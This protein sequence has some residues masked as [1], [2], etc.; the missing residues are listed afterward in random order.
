[1]KRR[2]SGIRLVI[3]DCDGVLADAD[4]SW[5]YVHHA[6]GTDNTES[7]KA[8]MRK[9][10]D[11]YE[12]I[13]RDVRL[14]ARNGERIHIS[15][16]RKILDG[17]P[18]MKGAP[19][20]IKELRRRGIMTAIVSGGLQPLTE[21]IAGTCGIDINLSNGLV[22]D[23]EGYVTGEGIVVVPV[24][25]KGAVVKKLVKGL[26]L[27]KEQCAAIGDR[28]LDS[29]MFEHVGLGI[30]F[31]PADQEVCDEAAVV[32]RKKDLREVL[33]YLLPDD[34][35]KG[36][37]GRKSGTRKTPARKRAAKVARK[38]GAGK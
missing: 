26:G 8:Y 36:K 16:I 19:E 32:I 12:F 30:A 7:L 21:R 20:A 35:K 1:M 4:S 11:D 24:S 9:E 3:F 10:F 28:G 2:R 15:I 34:R 23:N 25:D 14:W 31:N 13:R 27:K 17:V 22:T 6:F 33:R 37:G 18:L 29:R 38:K 5:E